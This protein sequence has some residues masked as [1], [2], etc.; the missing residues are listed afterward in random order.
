MTRGN[1]RE[2]AREKARKKADKQGKGKTTDGRALIKKKEDDANIMREKQ[3]VS[4]EAELRPDP[5]TIGLLKI[6]TTGVAATVIMAH[7]TSREGSWLWGSFLM[8]T[9]G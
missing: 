5:F 8:L 7:Q 6:E 9:G 1:Q 2:L 3:K 4:R